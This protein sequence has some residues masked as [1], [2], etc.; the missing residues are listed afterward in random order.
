M[1]KVNRNNHPILVKARKASYEAGKSVG[2][3]MGFKDGN[4]RGVQETERFYLAEIEC[5]KT[6]IAGFEAKEERTKKEE[7]KET[8][9]R[10]CPFCGG[11]AKLTTQRE[12]A[13]MGWVVTEFFVE[14]KDCGARSKIVE[15]D[16][17]GDK[18]YKE[19]KSLAIEVWN[20]RAYERKAD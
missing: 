10:P 1:A 20:R 3:R 11:E 15:E 19:L 6:I 17:N 9:L 12:N 5:L 16:Y 4:D 18:E 13:G 2:Y 14:C 8:E 7:S